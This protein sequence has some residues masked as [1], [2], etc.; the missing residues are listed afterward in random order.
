MLTYLLAD[1]LGSNS[2]ITSDLGTL[3]S[4]TRYKP[5]GEI[6]YATGTTTTP[7]TYTGQYSNTA[8]FG[9]MYYKAR[10][11]YPSLG[12]FGQADSIVPG[13]GD[14]RAWDRYSYV[15]NNPVRY[16]D[17]SGHATC[18]EDGNCYLKPGDRVPNQSKLLPVVN[19]LY[20]AHPRRSKEVERRNKMVEHAIDQ[21]SV[22]AS[23]GF[24]LPGCAVQQEFMSTNP[25]VDPGIN[26]QLVFNER[27][28]L[29]LL[30]GIDI[31]EVYGLTNTQLFKFAKRGLP[32]TTL[33]AAVAGGR[34]WYQDANSGY[35]YNGVQQFLRIAISGG[36]AAAIDGLST[37]VGVAF[38]SAASEIPIV[39][40]VVGYGGGSIL[41]SYVGEG[42]VNEINPTIFSIFRLGP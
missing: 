32:L 25:D 9:W 33:E 22:C 26:T 40:T 42:I 35:K 8:D 34:Q 36:E 20:G 15:K 28:V 3:L 6:R 7:Y 14:P 2:L 27:F 17:P 10:W 16:N 31:S 30:K 11:Y 18:D 24:A 13:A 4:E 29:P 38:G 1:H 39:G 23:H 21:L 12:R 41:T 5:F 19:S 37:L